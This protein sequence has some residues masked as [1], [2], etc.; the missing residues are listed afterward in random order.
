M[1]KRKSR[2]VE[3]SKRGAAG[4]AHATRGLSRTV[5][6]GKVYDRKAA[7]RA[8]LERICDEQAETL[9]RLEG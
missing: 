3:L 1:S 7:M 8:A 4:L 2:P 6:S 5:E 9:S